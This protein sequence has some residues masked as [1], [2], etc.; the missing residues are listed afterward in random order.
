M[1]TNKA[2]QYEQ[3]KQSFARAVLSLFTGEKWI[4]AAR[5]DIAAVAARPALFIDELFDD[6]KS[7]DTRNVHLIHDQTKGAMKGALSKSET[8]H[9]G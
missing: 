7:S 1:N 6:V 2:V 3:Q 5:L 4:I 8:C 9:F